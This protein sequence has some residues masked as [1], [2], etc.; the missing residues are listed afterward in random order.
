MATVFYGHSNRPSSTVVLIECLNYVWSLYLL[1]TVLSLVFFLLFW[2]LVTS[3]Y[4]GSILY[5]SGRTIGYSRQR[6][7]TIVSESF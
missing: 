5:G 2:Q 7:P 6:T 4:Y 3:L 1:D